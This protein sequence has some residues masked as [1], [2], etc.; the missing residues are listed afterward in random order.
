MEYHGTLPHDELMEEVASVDF[1]LHMAIAEGFPFLAVR[2]ANGLGVQAILPIRCTRN[3]AGVT[4]LLLTSSGFPSLSKPLS[5][6][7]AQPP[8][9]KLIER[10]QIILTL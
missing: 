9:S 3:P 10:A 8:H 7:G 1:I 6:T 2:E 4:M 5:A